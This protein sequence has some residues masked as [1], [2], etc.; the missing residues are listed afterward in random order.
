MPAPTPTR[1]VATVVKAILLAGVFIF[2][3]IKVVLISGTK[4]NSTFSTVETKPPAARSVTTTT[5]NSTPVPQRQ[6]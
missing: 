3:G 4:A 6:P 2:C 1:K 5:A